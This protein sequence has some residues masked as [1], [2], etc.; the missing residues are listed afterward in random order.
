MTDHP[1][2][3]VARRLWD[4]ISSGDRDGVRELLSPDVVW[5]SHSAGSLSGEW[6]GADAVLDLLARTGE[7][8]DQLRSTL[9]DI[10]ASEGG[11]VVR[12]RVEASRG[13]ERLETE[14]LV[15]QRIRD[16]RVIEATT[17]PQDAER[18][19]RFWRLH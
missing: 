1:N 18:N 19:L 10:Y 14:H 8:V 6:K 4:A 16:G 3:Y 5:R 9:C 13:A 7:L 15:I 2:M 11:A 17:V 12:Y